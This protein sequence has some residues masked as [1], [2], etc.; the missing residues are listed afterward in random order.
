M[1]RD[2]FMAAPL[3]IAPLGHE[4][5][6]AC[7]RLIRSE[8]VGPVSF[9]Q[10]I[11]HYGGAS[12]A[13]EAAPELARR[14]GGKRPFKVYPRDA[15]EREL[16]AAIRI[17][18]RPLFTIE[19]GYP[20]PLAWLDQPP[21]MIYVRGRTELFERP[22]VALV[23]SRRSS[24]A[25]QAMARSLAGALSK[26]GLVIISGLARGIDGAAHRA[27][28]AHGTVAVLAGGLDNIYPPE[29]AELHKQIAEAG[30]LVSER[31]PGFTPRGQD[32]PRRNR[33]ISGL[34]LGVIVVEAARRSGSLITARMAGEQGREVFAVPG[35]PLDPRA[36]GTN[37]LI[38]SGARMVT[39]GED[40]LDDLRP[41]LRSG[42]HF[43]DGALDAR[44]S[45]I[46][47]D[48]R[49]LP[50]ALPTDVDESVRAQVL[51]VLSPAPVEIDEL[52][53]ATGI[54]VQ[55]VKI[56]LLE[57]SLAGRLAYH[58]QNLV[59]LVPEQEGS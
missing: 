15:A 45:H 50:P 26:H 41:Q 32:F 9:R 54:S 42:P 52:V 48:G 51:A 25:G 10:L 37:D 35:H 8:R 28:L 24:A 39:C 47:G 18:A 12:R 3:P 56:A 44:A 49:S 20:K 30:C 17:G 22:A 55:N 57:I 58:G 43:S 38:K 27:A 5:R 23:G 33:I 59:S 4:E 13:L 34:S 21:P 19:P 40:V 16:E 2:L 14:G 53:R 1:E 31:P 46:P 36:E 6:I 11:N 29:H 7:L